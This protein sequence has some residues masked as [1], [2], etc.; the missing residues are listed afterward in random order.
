MSCRC[1]QRPRRQHLPPAC[2][3]YAAVRP[4]IVAQVGL[5]PQFSPRHLKGRC[6]VIML[7]WGAG[8]GGTGTG[9]IKSKTYLE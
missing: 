9:L 7:S 1:S 8:T 4:G 6:C 3:W 2:Q 5:L